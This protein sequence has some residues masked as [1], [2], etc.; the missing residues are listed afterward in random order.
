MVGVLV[1][2]HGELADALVGTADLIYGPMEQ[3]EGL[4]LS[5]DE[6]EESMIARIREA[7]EELD[8]GDGVLILVDM[9]GGTPSNLSLRLMQQ[10]HVEVV[11]GVNLPMLLK[12]GSRRKQTL[13]ELARSVRE[14]GARNILLAGE[15]LKGR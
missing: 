9:F 1:I 2:T 3:L 7:V 12:V 15:L 10:G 13:S 8:K 14:A 5:P 4:G 6:S 11:T